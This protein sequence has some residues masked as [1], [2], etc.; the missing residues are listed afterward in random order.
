M[1]TNREISAEVTDPAIKATRDFSDYWLGVYFNNPEK[2]TPLVCSCRAETSFD[3][4]VLIK[5]LC[6]LDIAFKVNW[7]LEFGFPGAEMELF[8]EIDVERLRD[9]MR[10]QSDMHIMIQS[11]RQVP[12]KDNSLERDDSIAW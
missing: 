8:T 6:D 1:R 10:M 5:A 11:L 12:L 2:P 9:I 7:W 4:A 3:V